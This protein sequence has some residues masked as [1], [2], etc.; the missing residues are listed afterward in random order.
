MTTLV[1]AALTLRQ[2]AR[3]SVG[4][5]L[6]IAFAALD[7]LGAWLRPLRELG[8]EH[9]LV[10][11][12]W[13]A[14]F[15]SRAAS[16]LKAED[17][18]R[19]TPLKDFEMGLYMLVAVHA[20]VQLGGGLTGQLYPIVYVL[21]AFLASFAEKPSGSV[22]VIV[23]VGFEAVLYFVTE[24]RRDP[25]PYFLHASFIVFFGLMNLLFTRV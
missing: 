10:A 4:F 13:A 11:T 25:E 5:L 23:A 15:L 24:G 19:L 22:L 3:A 20:V 8:T 14:L 9:A 1:F 12:V 6:A 7:V 17:K 16:R 18:S 21:V 2:T